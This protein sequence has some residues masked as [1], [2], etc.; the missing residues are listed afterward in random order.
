LSPVLIGWQV[1]G[2]CIRLVDSQYVKGINH[3]W[4]KPHYKLWCQHCVMMGERCHRRTRITGCC[5]LGGCQIVI[6]DTQQSAVA[7]REG[8]LTGVL[9]T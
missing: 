9:P 7:C 8:A 2:L 3:K 1:Y 4:D 5:L 6:D